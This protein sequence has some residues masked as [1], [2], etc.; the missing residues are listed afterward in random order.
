MFCASSVSKCSAK[1]GGKFQGSILQKGYKNLQNF[2]QKVEAKSRDRFHKTPFRPKKLLDKIS[3]SNFGQV[4]TL[5]QQ[6]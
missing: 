1:S 5:H 6:I 4:S 3:P 2:L